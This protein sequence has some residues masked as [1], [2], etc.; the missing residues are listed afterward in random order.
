VSDDAA[1][2]RDSLT[3]ASPARL[4]RAARILL[5][6]VLRIAIAVGC[7]GSS[8]LRPDL[9]LA[10][11]GVARTSSRS[12]GAALAQSRENRAPRARS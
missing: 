11:V 12:E 2:R 8:L 4:H 7:R 10:C 1:S 3:F 9:V 6:G 5:A